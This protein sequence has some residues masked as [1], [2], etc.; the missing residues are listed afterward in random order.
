MRWIALLIAT[1]FLIAALPAFAVPHAK[2]KPAAPLPDYSAFYIGGLDFTMPPKWLAVP[3]ETAARAGEWKI[4]VPRGSTDEGGE[5]VA[6]YFGPAKGGSAKES[7]AAWTASMTSADGRPATADTQVHRANG[8]KI[9]QVM[10]YGTYRKPVPLPGVPPVA[11]Q[12][13][14]LIGT[15][16]E[17]PQGN[18]YW[19]VTGPQPL[20]TANLPLFNQMIDSVKPQAK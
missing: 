3:A 6:F 9:S 2:R 1:G 16:V 5:V 7:I 12:N 15:V 14:A 20:I 13:Y 10:V 19:R 17:N 4:L 11:K 8:D 18:V